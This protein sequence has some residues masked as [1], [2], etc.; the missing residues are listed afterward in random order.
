MMTT[1]L[2]IFGVS[3]GFTVAQLKNRGKEWQANLLFG[4]FTL[5]LLGWLVYSLVNVL[6]E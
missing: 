3:V 6:Y 2:M 4:T 1:L 5:G